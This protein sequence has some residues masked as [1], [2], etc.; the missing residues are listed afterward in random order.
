VR[1]RD[2]RRELERLLREE[3]GLESI[4][5][6]VLGAGIALACLAFWAG[7]GYRVSGLLV[8]IRNLF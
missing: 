4:E 6:A 1:R 5:W 8:D 3:N 2:V 7:L